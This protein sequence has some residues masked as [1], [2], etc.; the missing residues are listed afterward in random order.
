MPKIQIS[1]ITLLILFLFALIL[2][3]VYFVREKQDKFFSSQRTTDTTQQ[4][5]EPHYSPDT[6][7]EGGEPLFSILYDQIGI[8][9]AIGEGF[10]TIEVEEGM[11]SRFKEMK[12]NLLPETEYFLMTLIK[13]PENGTITPDAFQKEKISLSEIKAGDKVIVVTTDN[14]AEKE[15]LRALRISVIRK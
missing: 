7:G 1:T 2:T 11:R 10:I 5:E 15:E 13:K 3:G 6:I 9:K 12:V 14:P 4:T 8:V